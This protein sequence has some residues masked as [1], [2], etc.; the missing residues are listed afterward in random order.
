MLE[1]F[2]QHGPAILAGMTAIGSL[3]ASITG[4]V[5]VFKTNQKINAEQAKTQTE[6]QI[7]REGII[8]AFKAAKIPNEWKVTVSKQVEAYLTKFRD[9]FITMFKENE[10]A[11]DLIMISILKILNFTAASNKLT[12]DEKKQI[13]D[14]IK[15][16]TDEDNT[17]DISE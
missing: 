7:T 16:I 15:Q 17:I 4:L 3:V 2:A 5:K 6:I 1:F 11:R 8:E 14:L 12:E 10:Q 13:D 9:E